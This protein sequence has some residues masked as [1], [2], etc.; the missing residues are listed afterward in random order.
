MV[1]FVGSI[2]V[3]YIN[4]T[5]AYYTTDAAL[6]TGKIGLRVNTGTMHLDNVKVYTLS[7]F[8]SR[9]ASH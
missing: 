6:S 4:D 8:D 9:L 1:R 5:L 7:G 2:I 3:V